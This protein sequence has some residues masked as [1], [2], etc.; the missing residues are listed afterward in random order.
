MSFLNGRGSFVKMYL[1]YR[2]FVASTLARLPP[3][4]RIP[5][6]NNLDIFNDLL[7]YAGVDGIVEEG[8]REGIRGKWTAPCSDPADTRDLSRA[9]GETYAEMKRVQATM[10]PDYLPHPV[11]GDLLEADWSEGRSAIQSQNWAGLDDFLKNFFRNGGISG[12]WGSG[13]MLHDFVEIDPWE[14]SLR[15]AM[16]LR[17][18]KAWKREIPG[19][20]MSELDHPRIGNPWGYDVDGK[21]VIEPEFEYHE[22]ANRIKGILA[23]VADPV[24]IEIGGGFGGFATQLLKTIPGV[25]YLGFDLPENVIIQS[26]NLTRCFPNLKVAF[27]DVGSIDGNSEAIILPNWS[28]R[29]ARPRKV[30]LILNVRSFAEMSRETL[31]A[32]F[33]QIDRID[34][35]WIYHENVTGTR[36]DGSHGVSATDYP[37]LTRYSLIT[38][39]ESRWPR[40]GRGSAYPCR[41]YL[42]RR[43]P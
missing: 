42:Y 17:Q 1:A 38:S 14:D 23:G 10:P 30:D 2:S 27:N 43:T 5:L 21:L 13:Q 41:E 36:K 19:R 39:N 25:R 32:Y 33:E 20:D 9:L 35:E 3:R 6:I 4:A 15:L 29:E 24:V 8:R 16:F 12:V 37:L 40:Y 18:L 28:L 7:R 34:P 31:A 26:Y 11:W 22:L